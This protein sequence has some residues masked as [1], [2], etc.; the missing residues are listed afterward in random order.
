MIG[1]CGKCIHF[2][3]CTVWHK[4]FIGKPLKAESLCEHF[5]FKADFVKVVRCMECKYCVEEYRGYYVCT[6][7]IKQHDVKLWHFCSYG[8]RRDT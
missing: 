2:E 8:E 3:R 6:L 1:D 7:P 5:K 4:M